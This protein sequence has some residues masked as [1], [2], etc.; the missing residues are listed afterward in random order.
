MQA[1]TLWRVSISTTTEAEDAVSE[2]LQAQFGQPASVYTDSESG[3]TQVSV[4]LSSRPSWVVERGKL[5]AAVHRLGDYGLNTSSVKVSLARLA[6]QDWAQSWKRH[7]RPIE[8]GS[9]LVIKPS[10]SKRRPRKGQASVIL[11]PGLSF[12]TGQHPTTH[13]CLS[14]LVAHRCPGQSQS[15]L[16]VGTGSGILAIAAARLGYTGIEALDFDREALRVARAN[17]ELNGVASRIYF[18]PRDLNRL[19]PQSTSQFSVVCANLVSHLLLEHKQK[20]IN[21]VEPDG[22]LVVAGIL[23]A[24]FSVVQRAYEAAGLK[25]TTSRAKAEWRSGAFSL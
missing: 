13:F 23:K 14:Q 15:L 1:K 8:I 9:R 22:L 7:F 21:R 5:V 16:D 17:A 18:L 4:F 3:A 20:L 2:V 6:S 24:E 12:G 25:L 10:W 11:D 19:S